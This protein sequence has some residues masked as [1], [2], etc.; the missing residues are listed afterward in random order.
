MRAGLVS[1]LGAVVV[2]VLAACGSG[3]SRPTYPIQVYV[4]GTHFAS[5]GLDHPGSFL[6]PGKLKI[7]VG[8]GN[9]WVKVSRAVATEMVD[10]GLAGRHGRVDLPFT[11]FSSYMKNS[12]QK[13]LFPHASEI[14]SLSMLLGPAGIDAPQVHLVKELPRSGPADPQPVAGSKLFRW[15]DPDR[16]FVG[17]PDGAGRA[18]FGVYEAPIR[19]LAADYGVDLIDL[20][21]KGVDAVRDALLDGHPVMAWV[22][23][24]GDG[25]HATWLT[26]S[27]KKITVNLGVR[28]VLLN[29]TGPGYYLLNDPVS[30]EAVKWTSAQ[31]SRRWELLGQRA[32]ELP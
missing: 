29:G 20:H 17:R 4:A 12:P 25:E 15:G 11:R 5:V 22:D 28:A 30:G 31:F 18:A 10:R 16:G 13:Q 24:T 7:H 19:R 9:M 26:P 3:Q 23:W 14:T 27:G 8:Y 32:L 6:P 21:G 2:L 1:A